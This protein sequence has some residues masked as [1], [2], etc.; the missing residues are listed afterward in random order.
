MRNLLS[1]SPSS[2][3]GRLGAAPKPVRISIEFVHVGAALSGHHHRLARRGCTK[4]R[5]IFTDAWTLRVLATDMK[6]SGFLNPPVT[7]V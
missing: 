2:W 7:P 6:P 3:V 1:T 4:T 5:V